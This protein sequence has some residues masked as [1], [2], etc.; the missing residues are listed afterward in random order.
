MC[1]VT[2]ED[3]EGQIEATIFSET[4]EEIQGKNADAVALEQIVFL[5]GKVD[6]RRE[7][8]GLIVNDL[9]PI[10][11]AMARF[12]R[13]IKVE[14]DRIEGAIE[15]LRELKSIFT[16][17]RGNCPT[18][19]SVP[20]ADAK[21]ALITLD[22]QWSVRPTPAVKQE[23]EFALNGHGRVE[24]AGAG[25]KRNRAAAQQ[26]MFEGAEVSSGESVIEEIPVVMGA[27]DEGD[28]DEAGY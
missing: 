7:K 9:I 12:T 19:L 28:V 23:L 10:S 21:R 4:L 5:K 20:T 15:T 25:T 26:Q 17:H 18:Y 24:L 22:R 13:G 11:D 27:G 3:L 6:K 16:K 2:L 14:I 8:P 1:I